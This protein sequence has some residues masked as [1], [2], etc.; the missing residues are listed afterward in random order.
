MPEIAYCASPNCRAD[1]L[2]LSDGKLFVCPT[3]NSK[4]AWLCEVCME[5][6]TSEWP[7]GVLVLHAVRHRNARA[8]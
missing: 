4:F 6:F 8:A 7:D 1:F 5:Q 2:R 3:D